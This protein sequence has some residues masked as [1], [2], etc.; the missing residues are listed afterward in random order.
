MRRR[1]FLKAIPVAGV[2]T[3]LLTH[4]WMAFSAPKL[5]PDPHFFVQIYFEGGMDPSYLFDARPLAMT[6]AGKIANYLGEEPAAWTDAAGRTTWAT[7]LTDPLKPYRDRFTILNGVVMT[8]AFDGHEQNANYL[9]AGDPFGGEAFVPHLNAGSGRRPVDALQAGSIGATLTNVGGIVPMGPSAAESLA[10]RLREYP[11]QSGDPVFDFVKG[12]LAAN[13]RG[14]GRFSSASRAMLS[15]LEGAPALAAMVREISNL[16]PAATPDR[17]FVGLMLDFFKQGVT[18][19][20]IIRFQLS[21]V[22]DTHAPSDAKKQ[23]ALNRQIVE[24]IA[25]VLKSLSETPYDGQRNFLDVTTFMIS[26]EFGRTFRQ[27]G[28]P[29]DDTGTDHN[30][31]CQTVLIGGKGIKNGMVIGASDFQSTDETLSPTHAMLDAESIRAMGRPFDHRQFTTRPDLPATYKPSD[32]LNL[33]SVVNTLYRLYN[34]PDTLHRT[35]GRNEPTAPV[36][37]GLLS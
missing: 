6:Q 29:I 33:A 21:S 24:K 28:K 3:L 11:I 35:Y 20:A 4:P 31:L 8:A 5:G 10:K 14:P 25:L 7:S 17:Q 22:L 37:N 12:R 2:G 13:G 26:S 27:I 18:P 32:Y 23:P 36:L 9:F 30:P 34:K 19:S 1:S 16:D 15:G